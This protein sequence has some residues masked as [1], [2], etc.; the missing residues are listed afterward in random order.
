MSD[1]KTVASGQIPIDWQ[2]EYPTGI[3]HTVVDSIT[4]AGLLIESKF[5]KS[6]LRPN[7]RDAQRRYDNYRVDHWNKSHVG[8]VT[9]GL[10]ALL[11]GESFEDPDI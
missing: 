6:R 5:G 9:G 11:F 2:V 10:P 7:Q 8:K 1:I 4:D 3:S